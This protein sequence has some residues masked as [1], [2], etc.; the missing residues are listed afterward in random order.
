MLQAMS[1]SKD[2]WTDT[3][4]LLPLLFR[5]TIDSYSEFLFG[6]SVGTQLVALPSYTGADKYK[7]MELVKA[8]ENSQECIAKAFRLYDF[9]ALGVT[10]KYKD[11]CKTVR[12]WID[13]FVQ[14]ALNHDKEKQLEGGEKERYV[15]L[16]QL[17]EAAQNP[18]EI[19]PATN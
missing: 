9:F 10:K 12:E 3:I 16:E 5:L 7:R 15:F 13:H 8:F 4:D 6:E 2:G 11:Y 1:V 14:K 19:R 17:A 18:I